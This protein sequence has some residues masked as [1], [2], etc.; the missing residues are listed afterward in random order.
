MSYISYVR[1]KDGSE[2]EPPTAVTV[3]FVMACG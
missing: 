2:S 1:L 3:N